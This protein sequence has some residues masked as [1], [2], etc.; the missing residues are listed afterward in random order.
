METHGKYC[1]FAEYYTRLSC[2]FSHFPKFV[3]PQQRSAKVHTLLDTAIHATIPKLPL[4]GLRFGLRHPR[5]DR[6][7]IPKGALST[8]PSSPMYQYLR[9]WGR[10]FMLTTTNGKN[11]EKKTEKR[12][13]GRTPKKNV[14]RAPRHKHSPL[15][16][17]FLISLDSLIQ[18]LFLPGNNPKLHSCLFKRL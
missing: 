3:S 11:N 17:C 8:S 5:E 4:F 2:T 1:E 7:N 16:V 13:C 6:N 14:H 10:L 9:I 15:G 18:R 12:A